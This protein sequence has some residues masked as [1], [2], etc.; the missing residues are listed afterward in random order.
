MLRTVAL[1][2]C[3]ALTLGP[4]GQSRRVDLEADDCSRVVMNFDDYETARAVRHTT[5]PLSIGR[6]DVRPDSNGGVRIER[7][8]AGAYSVTACVA[9][10]AR[11]FADAQAAADSVRLEV[12]GNRV[13]ATAPDGDRIR[14]W[15]VQLVIA[16]PAGADVS[17]VTRNGPIALDGVAGTFDVRAQ[18]GPIS[19]RGSQGEV[20]V[21][22]QNGPISIDLDGRRWDGHLTAHAG[23]GPLAVHVPED[24]ASGVEISSSAHAPWSCHA[25]AC[26]SSSRD[27]DDRSRSLR[28]GSDPVVVRIST[29]NG[30]VSVGR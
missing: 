19:V 30:P 6:L 25:S 26:R 11:S 12:D 16:A 2:G 4:A 10:G 20:D 8:T 3:F 27:W 13:R 14:T 28:L 18:N 23:N 24:Y 17:V 15:S 1:A 22:T 7:G 9:A 5:I 29:N 21:E